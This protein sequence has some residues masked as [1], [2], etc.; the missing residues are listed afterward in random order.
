MPCKHEGGTDPCAYPYKSPNCIGYHRAYRKKNLTGSRIGSGRQADSGYVG[1]LIV[2][3][4]LLLRGL[5]VTVPENRNSPD[6]VHFKSSKGWVSVQ[7]RVVDVNESTGHW[8]LR[9]R[10]GGT[11][12]TSDVLA[13][14]NL[15]GKAIRYVANASN[16]PEEL[17]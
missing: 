5:D 10:K 11:I 4:D 14:V 15:R 3:T 16:V 6:D 17:L 9:Q 7:V 12:P 8:Y 1:E 13:W 2:R